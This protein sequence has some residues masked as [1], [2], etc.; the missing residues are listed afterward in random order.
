M[1]TKISFFKNLW[2]RRVPHIFIIYLGACWAIIEFV[3]SLLVDRYLLSP[4]LIDLSIVMLLS[5]I[6][7]V[8]LIA[9]F[10]GKPGKDEWTRF[11]KIGIPIN[12]II[13]ISLLFFVF[14]GK[15]LG[16]TTKTV[17]LENEK[18]EKIKRMI[19]KSEFR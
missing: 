19:P 18:G 17:T 8:L 3:S 7:S 1:K 11:E 5:L 10:H 15:D 9:Y 12:I 2:Q 6:P 16:A 4:H 13:S 14:Q